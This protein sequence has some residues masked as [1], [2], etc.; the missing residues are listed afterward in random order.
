MAMYNQLLHDEQLN[1]RRTRW[2]LTESRKV[3]LESLLTRFPLLKYQRPIYDD[4]I[5]PVNLNNLGNEPIHTLLV[6]GRRLGKSTLAAE[7]MVEY[8]LSN[9][10]S[11]YI[12]PF[13][14]QTNVLWGILNRIFTKIERNPLIKE[15]FD[16]KFRKVMNPRTIESRI[17]DQNS[18]LLTT[19][20]DEDSIRGQWADL[21]IMDE[22][23][24]QNETIWSSVV[25]P[26]LIDKT[27]KALFLTTPPNPERFSESKAMDQ[28]HLLDFWKQCESNPIF[29]TYNKSTFENETLNHEYILKVEQP[30]KSDME[31]KT[32]ILAEMHDIQNVRYFTREMFEQLPS[33]LSNRYNRK[34]VSVDPSGVERRNECGILLLAELESSDEYAVLEDHSDRTTPT[35]WANTAL[36]LAIVN[37]CPILVETN[38]GGSMPEEMIKAQADIRQLPYPEIIGIHTQENKTARVGKIQPL[39]KQ[40]KVYHAPGLIALEQQMVNFV[41]SP[42]ESPD[43]LDALGHGL[44]YLAQPATQRV[45]Y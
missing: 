36:N 15:R 6:G 7:L 21:I 20:H 26:M 27:G 25:S 31:W 3:K 39:Y 5:L 10:K 33:N 44:Y 8:L 22:Y 1:R 12:S 16:N 18:I 38:Y 42:S 35:Q 11:L 28:F 30:I 17:T 23:A 32:E 19:S 43:R 14:G 41:P 9:R 2:S 29:S 24:Y 45:F 40:K 13:P 37:D 4:I 34:L